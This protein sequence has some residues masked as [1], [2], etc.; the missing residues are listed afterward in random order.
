MFLLVFFYLTMLLTGKFFGHQK[1]VRQLF[2]L[3]LLNV[4]EE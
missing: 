3:E 2:I 4:F 1:F